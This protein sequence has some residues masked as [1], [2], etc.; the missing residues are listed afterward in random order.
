VPQIA[1]AKR[2]N[3]SALEPRVRRRCDSTLN[4]ALALWS[5]LPATLMNHI[6]GAWCPNTHLGSSPRLPSVRTVL[7]PTPSCKMRYCFH[8]RWRLDNLAYLEVI[9][10]RLKVQMKGMVDMLENFSVV[11]KKTWGRAFAVLLAFSA[12]LSGLAQDVRRTI[13]MV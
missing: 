8:Y 7:E 1:P 4:P 5:E 12:P 3:A 10:Y 11:S 13:L 9:E 2:R 6:S